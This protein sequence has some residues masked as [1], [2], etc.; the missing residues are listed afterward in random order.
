MKTSLM[1]RK[2]QWCELEC[3]ECHKIFVRRRR[4]FHINGSH[5]CR[6]ECVRFAKVRNA[7]LSTAKWYKRS[8]LEKKIILERKRQKYWDQNGVD[9]PWKLPSIRKQIEK[10]CLEKYGF[11]NPALSSVVMAKIDQ[12]A[13]HIKGHQTRKA[14]GSYV[15]SKAE[16]KFYAVL[17]DVFCLNDVERQPVVNGWSIDF[18]VK[19]INVYVQFDGIHWHGLDRPIKI[20]RASIR[21]VDKVILSTYERDAIQNEW[22]K[23]NGLQLE[24]ITDV[25]FKKNEKT[26]MQAFREKIHED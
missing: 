4:G 16:D 10:T 9:H 6:A 13:L 18:Y 3:D 8:D 12:R 2:Q 5:L 7:I 11:K 22:F 24:R 1:G 23:E 14:N 25:Q 17:C 20:I 21:P 19:S 26:V 15:R